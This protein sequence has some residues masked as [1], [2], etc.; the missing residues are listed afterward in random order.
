[1]LLPRAEEIQDQCFQDQPLPWSTSSV[2]Y[3]G[4]LPSSCDRLDTLGMGT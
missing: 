4:P 3:S 2:E 1:M